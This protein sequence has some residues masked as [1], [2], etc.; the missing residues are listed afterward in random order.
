MRPV[1]RSSYYRPAPGEACRAAGAGAMRKIE[2]DARARARPA[3]L[4]AHFM[5]KKAVKLY[6]ALISD[7]VT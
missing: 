5:K 2:D 7:N 3:G 6:S 1:P 4:H